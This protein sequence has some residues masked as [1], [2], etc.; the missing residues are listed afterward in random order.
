MTVGGGGSAEVVLVG[1]GGAGADGRGET[2]RRI[3]A[4]PWHAALSESR[5]SLREC[6]RRCNGP[7]SVA[8]LNQGVAIGFE[9]FGAALFQA[10]FRLRGERF[11]GRASRS[12]AAGLA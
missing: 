6:C 4:E 10:A 11:R 7:R 12:R 1:K 8:S 3:T 2:V 5:A 9:I